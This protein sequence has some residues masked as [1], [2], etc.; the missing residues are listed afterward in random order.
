MIDFFRN[1]NCYMKYTSSLKV[2]SSEMGKHFYPNPKIQSTGY[3]F[4]MGSGIDFPLV[5]N[6]IDTNTGNG[7]PYFYFLNGHGDVIYFSDQ[8]F[9]EENIEN[10]E[11]NPFG[12]SNTFGI[13]N[14]LM[15][16]KFYLDKEMQYYYY[17][18]KI[19]NQDL[20]FSIAINKII[21]K[22]KIFYFDNLSEIYMYYMIS[23][24]QIK[25][26]PSSQNFAACKISIYCPEERKWKTAICSPMP[27]CKCIC[28]A[29]AGC[30]TAGNLCPGSPFVSGQIVCCVE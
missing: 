15:F 25:A 9:T 6:Y 17:N 11:Y 8:N 3:F 13:R 12:K 29:S 22:L 24:F 4:P 1:R 23:S 26:S 30:A 5:M 18:S 27:G 19:Y 16:K 7:G 14:S 2:F 28:E 21:N 20:G 10:Y